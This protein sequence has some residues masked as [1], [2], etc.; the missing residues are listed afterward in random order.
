MG[1]FASVLTLWGIE[2]KYSDNLKLTFSLHIL[3]NWK[4]Q[5]DI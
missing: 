5:Y 4:N 2:G 1:G 3:A